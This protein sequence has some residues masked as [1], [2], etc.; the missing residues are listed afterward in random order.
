MVIIYEFFA[1]IESPDI[2][3]HVTYARGGLDTMIYSGRLQPLT[4]VL[5]ALVIYKLYK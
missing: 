5:L 1:I 2:P 4:I 3:Q